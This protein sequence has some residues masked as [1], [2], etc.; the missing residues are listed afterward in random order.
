MNACIEFACM[1]KTSPFHGDTFSFLLKGSF[2]K[3]AYISYVENLLNFVNIKGTVFIS[4]L[5]KYILFC[6][7]NS[8]LTICSFCGWSL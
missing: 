5:L 1:G 6:I 7:I 8:L 3:N 2:R 4:K